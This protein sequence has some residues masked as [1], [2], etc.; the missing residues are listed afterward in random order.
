MTRCALVHETNDLAAP[1]QQ[2]RVI[3]RLTAFLRGLAGADA[4]WQPRVG[5]LELAA[6]HDSGADREVQDYAAAP[7]TASARCLHASAEAA[8]WT[9]PRL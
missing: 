2:S 9:S 7:P 3:S 6:R 4:E 1:S 8:R 5:R